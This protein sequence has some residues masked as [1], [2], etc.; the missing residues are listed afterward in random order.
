[1]IFLPFGELGNR[2][3]DPLAAFALYRFHILRNNLAQTQSYVDFLMA[4]EQTY[5]PI[6]R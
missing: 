2:D 1:M 3:S 5:K 4:K 6:E